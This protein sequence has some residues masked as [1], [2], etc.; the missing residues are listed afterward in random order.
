[1]HLYLEAGHERLGFARGR[2]ERECVVAPVQPVQSRAIRP[3]H[4]LYLPLAYFACIFERLV[5]NYA[6]VYLAYAGTL[7]SRHNGVAE[8]ITALEILTLDSRVG[9]SVDHK[10]AIPA[11]PGSIA[12]QH[13]RS[14]EA[15]VSPRK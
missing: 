4:V 14:T 9:N 2:V 8:T 7:H 11:C 3:R 13:H 12:A 15:L 10:V 5:D 6:A 1:M